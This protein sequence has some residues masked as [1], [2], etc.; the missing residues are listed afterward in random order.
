MLSF[1]RSMKWDGGKRALSMAQDKHPDCLANKFLFIR[2]L[3]VQTICVNRRQ[4]NEEEEEE[5]SEEAVPSP[6]KWL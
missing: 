3:I 2:N 6:S 4:E 1:N 5:R